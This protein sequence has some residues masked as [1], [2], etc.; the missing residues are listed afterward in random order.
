MNRK[1]FIEKEISKLKR[2]K[3]VLRV[4]KSSI[5]YSME[6]KEVFIKEYLEGTLP[7]IIFEKYGFD[8]EVLGYKRIEQAAA[9]WKKKYNENGILG[10]KDDRKTNSGRPIVK[11]L[12]LEEKYKKLEA[13]NKL[14]EMENEFLKKLDKLER[15]EF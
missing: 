6:F 10:L 4:S 14:L 8:I 15:G 1:Y 13:K 2:N 5:T 9:R 12:S 3:Y 11:E 7:R